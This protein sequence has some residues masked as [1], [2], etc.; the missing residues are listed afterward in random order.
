M[1]EFR[2]LNYKPGRGTAPEKQA[3]GAG[4]GTMVG[5]LVTSG[6]AAGAAGMEIGKR[7]AERE[8]DKKKDRRNEKR[9]QIGKAK[10]GLGEGQS[11]RKTSQ[12]DM[13]AKLQTGYNGP[14]RGNRGANDWD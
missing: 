13:P 6:A 1:A 9:K 7:R 12:S 14:T 4:V 2:G 3:Q 8:A 5:G 11:A 10:K